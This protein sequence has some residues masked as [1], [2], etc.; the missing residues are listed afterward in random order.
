MYR[1]PADDKSGS[2][3]SAPA[4]APKTVFVRWHGNKQQNATGDALP[5]REK[6]SSPETGEMSPGDIAKVTQA[7][8]EQLQDDFP[9]E[10]EEVGAAEFEKFV[11]AKKEKAKRDAAKARE[12]RVG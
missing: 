11:A 9:E 12:K 7:K 5:G 4:P 3:A 2:G 10:F 1:M 8:A 6:Y